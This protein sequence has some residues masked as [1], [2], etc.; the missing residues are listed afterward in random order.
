MTATETMDQK[1]QEDLVRLRKLR[2][3]D[4]AFFTK[5]FDGETACVKLVLQIILDKPDLDVVDVR[6]QV[7]VEHLLN[8]SVRLDVLATDSEGR[9]FNIEI[10]RSDKGAGRKR[11]RYN[12]SM[13]DVNLLEKGNDFEAL[14][15]TYVIFLTENDVIGLGEAVYEIERCFV[16]SGKRFGDGSH[17]LYVN[18]SYRD[19]SPVGKLMHDFSCTDPS[20]MCY[21]VL[22]DRA[23]FFKESKEGIA[24]MCKVLDDMRR[25]SYQEGMAEGKNKNR[26]ETALNLLKLGTISLDDISF[27]TGLSLDEVK[28]LNED[29][30]A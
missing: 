28:K 25:Q 27:A 18:G 20:D 21:N 11:A 4:D 9:K 1:H 2:L 3:M 7:F 8:R 15:E 17:I 5:C 6:T 29:K 14:P 10:Q 12:S 13:M 24:V 16:K 22:A 19:D 23:R 30:P 26:K